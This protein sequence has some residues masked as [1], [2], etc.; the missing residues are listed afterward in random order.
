VEGDVAGA[1][2]LVESWLRD[3]GRT[4]RGPD[5]ALRARALLLRGRLAADPATAETDYITVALEHPTSPA[6][7]EALLRLGQGAHARGDAARATGYLERLVLD[8]PGT[9]HRAPA[10]LWLAR[11]LAASGRREAG[12]VAARQGLGTAPGDAELTALLRAEQAGLCPPGA[13]APATALPAPPA[14]PAP[15]APGQYAVQCGAFR[16][17]ASARTFAAELRRAGVEPAVLP[18]PASGLVRVRAG[19]YAT[20]SAAAAAVAQ[21]RQ[22]GFTCYVAR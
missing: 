8:Y 2:G 12:C 6:A 5:P 4:R 13:A 11:A 10:H 19:Q 22:H 14:A 1:L 15:A 21:L 16:T 17:A 20:P 3:A 18:D 7:Q 9:P